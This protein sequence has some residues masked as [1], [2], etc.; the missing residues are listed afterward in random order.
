MSYSN[1][2]P[3]NQQPYPL[4]IPQPKPAQTGKRG[5]G[6][7]VAALIV[8]GF[9][10]IG[11][12]IPIIN[13]GAGFVGLVGLILGIVALVLKNRKKGFAIAGTIVSGVAIILSIILA[14]VY[15]AGFA[16]AVSD[17]I[18]TAETNSSASPSATAPATRDISVVYEVNGT[19]TDASIVYSTYANGT[20][21]TEQATGQALP[22]IKELTVQSGDDLQFTSFTLVATNG[23][24]D[25]GAVS[26]KI[27][28]D[29]EVVAEQSSTGEF[30]T[31][32]CSASG[33][34]G[35]TENK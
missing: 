12:F 1:Q 14:I 25:T 30:A 32:S 13:Y 28:V 8:G 3:A 11:S 29:G 15:T 16:G 7:G 4:P 17:A 27:T 9:A 5:N 22:F 35:V 34:D 23:A 18:K 2:P 20:S 6:V 31:V 33:V 10:L 26:C 21:G 24:E 19:S